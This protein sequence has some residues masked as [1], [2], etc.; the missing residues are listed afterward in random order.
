MSWRRVAGGVLAVVV[1]TGLT[2]CANDP[3]Q[4]ANPVVQPGKPG[5][6]NRT[7]SADEAAAGVPA[8]PPNEADFGYVEMMVVHHRQAVEMTAWAPARAADESVKGLASRISDTQQPEIDM[9]NAW[10]ERNGRPKAGDGHA[11]G[12]GDHAA[13]MP[14]MATPEQL[15]QLQGSTGAAFDALFL[16]LMTAHHEG[17]V[18]MANDVQKNGSDVKVQ[19]MA[20]H[21]IAEQSDEI[22]RM[23]AML[24][25]R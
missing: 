9:M 13:H 21:V 1:A 18:T 11:H 12:H 8:T 24:G 19:E 5:E 7:L 22:R 16:Q 3:A 10:L 14:G 4:P 25:A 15:R 23:R 6:S 2:A 17:A 20:D